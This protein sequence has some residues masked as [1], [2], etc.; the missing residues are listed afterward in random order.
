MESF[1]PVKGSRSFHKGY[2]QGAVAMIP[3]MKIF[4]D[5]S[6]DLDQ[7]SDL[8]SE[9]F[10]DTMLEGFKNVFNSK[11]LSDFE[12]IVKS[13]VDSKNV[14]LKEFRVHKIV[15]A[16]RSSVFMAMFENKMQEHQLNQVIIE[17]FSA[18]SVEEFLKFLYTGEIPDQKNAMEL[19]ALASKYDVAQLKQICNDNILKNLDES[20]A[21]EVLNLGNLYS[22]DGIIQKSFEKIVKAF[23]EIAFPDLLKK[24]PES[25]KEIINEK[26]QHDAKI[27]QR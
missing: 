22:S 25:V 13:K 3:E 16:T 18:E 10:V 14:E 26:V 9:M 4:L 1:S 12:I 11:Q 23:P 7:E 15:L 24:Y 19:F 21:L 2:V 27:E 5:S 17:D 20:N 6:C 8:E